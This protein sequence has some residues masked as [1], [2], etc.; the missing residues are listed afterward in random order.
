MQNITLNGEWVLK[1]PITNTTY[2][3]T[4]PGDVH[5][6][7][8]NSS[9]IPDP[10][11]SDNANNCAWVAEQ[12]WIYE[13]K[14]NVTE[15]M[16]K[17]RINLVFDGIDTFSEIYIND[18]K[19]ADTNNM[20]LQYTFTINEYVTA[21][22]NTLTVK[23][24]SIRQKAAQYP[25][26][27][28][29]GC[30]DVQR[31]FIRKA[32]CHFSWDWAPNFP[33][34]GI[35]QD[36][37]LEVL[38]GN[39]ISHVTIKPE[40]DG[41]AAI[42]VHLGKELNPWDV[43]GKTLRVKV[44]D[45]DTTVERTVN[46]AG[47][48]T[49]CNVFVNNV[50]LWWPKSLGEPHLY[51]YEVTLIENECETYKKS[52]H[53]GF[54]TVEHDQSPADT[55][56]FYC[57]FKI[58]SKEIF[59]K[60]ANWVPLDI[61]TGCISDDKYRKAIAMAHDAN[62]NCLRVWG[63]G[64]YEKEIFY[65]ICDQTGMLVWQDFQFACSDIPDDY[66]GFTE[67]VIEEVEYQ[68]NRL[69]TRPSF[70]VATGGNEKTGTYGQFKS[71][72]DH[73]VY[74]TIC[75]ICHHLDGTRPYMPSSPY[76]FGSIGND[77]TS[78]DSHVNSYEPSIGKGRFKEFREILAE[79]EA[80]MASEI[81]IQGACRV[82]SL[83]KYIPKE[84]LW[85]VNEIYNLH[86]TRNPYDGF[87]G[88]PFVEKQITAA[89]EAF[90]EFDTVNQYVKYSMALHSEYVRAD[91]EFHRS[92]KGNCGGAMF[93]M[94]SDI[95]PSGTWA[96]LDYYMIPK[97]AYYA[98]KR[99]YKPLTP[100]ITKHKDGV[101]AFVVN[102]TLSNVNATLTLR[103][104]DTAGN[105]YSEKSIDVKANA[106][107][108]T[109]VICVDDIIEYDTNRILIGELVANGETTKTFF[110]PDLWKDAPWCDPKL[111]VSV[112]RK[113]DKCAT[114]TIKATSAYARMVNII[115]PEFS[116][117][118][119]SDN[120]FDMEKGETRIIEIKSDSSFATEDILVKTWLDE[121]DR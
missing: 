50:K 9:V 67:Q 23:L 114:V 13:K 27:G 107:A 111:E 85:P 63:G 75:G 22:E 17:N 34:M 109:K 11:Y 94:C 110:F 82:E 45:N 106:N 14:F 77:L 3:A 46:V 59:L 16:L 21:G 91:S 1:N 38:S 79:K 39:T 44:W 105:V 97:A 115:V 40:L 57:K 25:K 92:R 74:Y 78:G 56:K 112:T 96:L 89:T 35:W 51:N 8:L 55:Q 4:V 37:R 53:F 88:I 32:Q 49:I 58:N 121:W 20:F 87:G 80:P 62:F 93:W 43:G 90:G 76:S 36:V 113:C 7:L 117:T 60:G 72:G 2:K 119:I 47:Y 65:D 98:A 69:Q 100:I 18:K 52:G 41:R 101:F 15:E 54:R 30:F 29:F 108:S 33:A 12:D 42:I 10:Y 70:F 24:L 26:E 68:I 118:Y 73:L 86:F 83:K 31:I 19:I 5:N 120:F 71:R 81:A 6:D 61:M 48:K 103:Y 102:D 99:S 66:E 84:S 116:G 104:V 64:I 28:Y 95:W